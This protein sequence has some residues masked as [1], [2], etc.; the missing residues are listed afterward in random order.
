VRW[1]EETLFPATE[2][3]LDARELDALGADLAGRLP[4]NP[5]PALDPPQHS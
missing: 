1:E 5:I 2:Q 4:T 3:T